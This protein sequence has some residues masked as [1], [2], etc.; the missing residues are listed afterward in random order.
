MA[1]GKFAFNIMSRLSGVN[2]KLVKLVLGD[3]GNHCLL[4]ILDKGNFFSQQSQHVLRTLFQSLS[5]LVG[6]IQGLKQLRQLLE[7][8]EDYL[9]CQMY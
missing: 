3:W 5:Q 9:I 6:S 7:T 1:L 8:Y 2:E 4:V